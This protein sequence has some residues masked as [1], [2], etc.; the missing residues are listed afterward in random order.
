MGSFD[1]YSNYDESTSHSSI[2]FGADKPV[3]EVELNEMQQI[4]NTKL[5]RIIKAV[6]GTSSIAFL[7][8]SSLSFN[9]SLNLARVQNCI[10]VTDN[11][12]TAFIED[13]TVGV[14]STN[15]FLFVKIQEEIKTGDDTLRKYG[16][17]IGSVIDNPIMDSRS[18][19]ETTRRKVVTW[20]LQSGSSVPKDT[21]TTKYVKIGT[22]DSTTGK[23][24]PEVTNRIEKLEKQLN[25]MALGVDENGLVYV[26]VADKVEE[27]EVEDNTETI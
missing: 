20:T 27:T 22:F 3:L 1:K 17:T 19:I 5:S 10:V 6:L 13:T 24:T 16:N 26:E 15:K 2:I 25:A 18:S 8:D 21:N 14:S 4:I 9:S 23:I 12:L 11:G 7:E